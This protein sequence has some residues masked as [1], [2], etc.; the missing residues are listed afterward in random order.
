MKAT[1]YTYVGPLRSAD[2]AGG[3][4]RKHDKREDTLGMQ[5]QLTNISFNITAKLV[6]EWGLVVIQP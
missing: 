3:N 1:L 6:V 5:M 4:P 2:R